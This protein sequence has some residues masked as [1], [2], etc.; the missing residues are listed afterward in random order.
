MQITREFFLQHHLELSVSKSKIMEYNTCT[1]ETKFTGEQGLDDIVLENVMLFKYLGIHVSSSPYCFFRAFN[2]NAKSIARKYMRAVL[3]LTRTG[4][5]RS[6]LAYSLW[7][8]CDLPAILYGCEIML[9]NQGTIK[10]LESIQ[11]KIG[12][13]ILQ[14]PTGSSNAAVHLDAGLKPVW[15]VIAERVI[16]YAKK[17]LEKPP[18][19]W[20]KLALIENLQ[21][22]DSPYTKY[23]NE[24]KMKT[25]YFGVQ[26]PQ[27]KKNVEYYAIKSSLSSKRS[28]SVTSF[29]MNPPGLV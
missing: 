29:A 8:C 1:K 23:L 18:G 22:K 7:T 21:W 27:I 17:I 19:Y 25:D 6:N 28:S 12:R 4:P 14:L 20:P 11:A 15:S 5:D 16:L 24:W 3:S 26:R 9:L 10:E 2:E 13:Y